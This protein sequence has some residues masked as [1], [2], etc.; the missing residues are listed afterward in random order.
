MLILK[1]DHMLLVATRAVWR[2]S[3]N[4]PRSASASQFWCACIVKCSA[5]LGSAQYC[6]Q[7]CVYCRY[8][9]VQCT[10]LFCV[11]QVPYYVVYCSYR[12]CSSCCRNQC[13]RPSTPVSNIL[14]THVRRGKLQLY[15]YL[16]LVDSS[17]GRLTMHVKAWCLN[18]INA[19]SWYLFII[20]IYRYLTEY[21]NKGWAS[22]DNWVHPAQQWDYC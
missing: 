5:V 11:L 3:A 8:R 19:A 7:Y 20:K 16:S 10:T 12:G 9:T 21:I 1:F 17:V 15:L 4:E 18:Y 6:A 22:I 14:A 13:L 2:G